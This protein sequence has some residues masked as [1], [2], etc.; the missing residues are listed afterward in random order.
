MRYKENPLENVSKRKMKQPIES[1]N[2]MPNKKVYGTGKKN[3]ESTWIVQ[4]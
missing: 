2:S 4:R 1:Q 3:I